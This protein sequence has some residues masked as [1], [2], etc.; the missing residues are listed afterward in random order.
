RVDGRHRYLR[1]TILNLDD[2]PL[3]GIDVVALAQ[4]RPLLVEGGHPRPLRVLY[5]SSVAPPPGY[6]FARPP[7]PKGRAPGTLGPE[8]RSAAFEPPPDTRSF[9]AR[10][11][12]LVTLA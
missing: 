11:R 3:E 10:H 12:G 2:P 9:A 7:P 4:P 1:L 6:A 8:R 5:G